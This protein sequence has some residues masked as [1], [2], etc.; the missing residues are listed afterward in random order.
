MDVRELKDKA[1]QL[2]SKGKFAKAAETYEEYCRADSK[3]LQARLRLGDAWSKAGKKDKAVAAYAWAAEGFAKDGFLP[4]AIAASKLV[5]EHDPSHKGVQ[6]MLADLYAQ[7]SSTP[8]RISK[9]PSPPGFPEI[10]RNTV[11]L[12]APVGD[13]LDAQKTVQTPGFAP[14]FGN[15]AD[16]IDL[17]APSSGAAKQG[18]SSQAAPSP[19]NRADAIDVPEFSI[20]LETGRAG[21]IG[22]RAADV[23]PSPTNRADAIVIELDKPKKKGPAPLE[24]AE[25]QLDLGGPAAGE[26]EIAIEEPSAAQEPGLSPILAA[27]PTLQST[28]AP[29]PIVTGQPLPSAPRQPP[30]PL[31]IS[32]ELELDPAPSAPVFELTVEESAPAVAPPPFR[33]D[34]VLVSLPPISR[35]SQVIAPSLVPPPP[36]SDDLSGSSQRDGSRPAPSDLPPPPPPSD[37][38]APQGARPAL[39][40]PPPPADAGPPPLLRSRP[41]QVSPSPVST[42]APQP[43]PMFSRPS[44]ITAAPGTSRP[45]QILAPPPPADAAPPPGLRPKKDSGVVVPPLVDSSPPTYQSSPSRIRLPTAFASQPSSGRIDVTATPADDTHTTDLE[46]SLQAFMQT[47]APHSSTPAPVAASFTELEIETES[48]LH[49]VEAAAHQPP[50]QVE[51]AM[52]PLD[53]PK[54]EAGALPRIP[55]FSDLP[56]DAFIALF[57]QCPLRRFDDGQTIIEQGTTGESFFVICAGRVRVFR[58]DGA[59][60]REVATLDEGA[61]FGE[62]ALLSDAPRSA[63][64]LAGGED[65]QVLEI[66]AQLLKDLS[67][68]YPTVAQALKKFCRQRLLSNLMAS[69][70]LF[71]P[72]SRSDRRDLIQKFR[73]REVRAGDVVVREGTACDGLYVVLSGEV[74]VRV[75]GARVAAL[76]E[77]EIFGE[78][79][80]LTKSAA[81]ASVISLRHT[82]LLRLPREDF[83]ALILSYPQI[84]EHVAELTDARRQTN[85]GVV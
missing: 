40:P 6:K 69:A 41:S 30:A 22:G 10:E 7:K 5:L 44:Q 20:P 79:S 74:E 9:L 8:S 4:R 27:L 38:L 68:K 15:R 65:T 67:T 39:S 78:M 75:K 47:D 16:A 31:P 82:S 53:D 12:A 34:E 50:P 36:P 42:D 84:L 29:P 17:D 32:F 45:S 57:E 11:D 73:A 3:D 51:E 71:R 70:P 85:G 14:G 21:G 26:V 76:R 28:P 56:A 58:T 81:G 83:D 13:D 54:P 52:E 66:S 25:V 1:S 24:V 19:M 49:A 46:R 63:S 35:P 64:V 59:S 55:L 77:G 23:G 61:F 43:Q 72:F 48:L 2:F 18:A 33:G 80:L 62:M 37:E 60:R